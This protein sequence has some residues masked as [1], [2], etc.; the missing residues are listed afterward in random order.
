MITKGIIVS[1]P[2]EPT[3]NKYQVRLPFFEDAT[4]NADQVIYEATLIEAPGIIQGYDIDDVVYCD[5]EDND[6]GRPV[7]LGKLFSREIENRG[8]EIET[9]SLV[10]NDRTRLSK[11]TSIGDATESDVANIKNIKNKVDKMGDTIFGALTLNNTVNFTAGK[12]VNLLNSSGEVTQTITT[13]NL[14]EETGVSDYDELSNRPSINSVTLTGNKTSSDLSLQPTLI[15]SGDDQNIKTI[16]NTS[17]LGVGDIS[18]LNL[19]YPVG[20]IYMST[21]NASPATFLGGTWVQI[22]DTFLL[23]AGDTYTA[24][25]TGGE[26]EHTLIVDEIPSHNHTWQTNNRG[27]GSNQSAKAYYGT[28]A[29]TDYTV[30]TGNRGGGKAHNNMPPYLVVYV[31]ERTA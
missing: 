26:A 20:S 29:G 7:I 2:V 4:E 10:V 30:N 27:S 12:K 24:G 9:N 5:F 21:V 16:N 13:N 3:D 15:D 18:I 14:F 19:I 23:S 25:S 8:A 31:W 6:L 1:I 17:L 22:K 28:N 11:R